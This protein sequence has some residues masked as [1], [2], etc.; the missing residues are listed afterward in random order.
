LPRCCAACFFL[1]GFS[2][3]LHF[4]G[5]RRLRPAVAGDAVVPPGGGDCVALLG[6]GAGDGTGQ[7][8]LVQTL[9]MERNLTFSPEESNP[10][11]RSQG[12]LRLRR[13][14]HFLS[15]SRDR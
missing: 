10:D 6:P 4:A 5:E 3:F 9:N 14:F 1:L 12:F 7:P 13:L 15:P 11:T 8:G 2:V